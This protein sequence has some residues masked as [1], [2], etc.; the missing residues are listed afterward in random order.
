M[1]PLV[2]LALG[3]FSVAT[4]TTALAADRTSWSEITTDSAAPSNPDEVDVTVLAIDG[5]MMFERMAYRLTPGFHLLHI[6]TT[7]LDRRGEATHQP[8]ALVAKPC[9]R[10]DL[11]AIHENALGNRRWEIT[12]KSESPIAR[13][14]P[15]ASEP[16]A[17]NAAAITP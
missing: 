16:A 15:P 6:A 1:K 10:Y 3:L 9:V 8:F 4:T 17:G 7:R 5:R 13:C 2:L 14:V 12:V 11:V